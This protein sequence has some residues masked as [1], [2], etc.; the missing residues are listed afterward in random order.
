M[1]SFSVHA[2][3]RENTQAPNFDL[4]SYDGLRVQLETSQSKVTIVNFWASWC[5]PCIKS[6]DHKIIPLY[7]EYDR[8]EVNVIGISN[9][10]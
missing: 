8:T 2:Q 10:I 3:L 4:M 9:D 1:L 7:N 6:L 5:G